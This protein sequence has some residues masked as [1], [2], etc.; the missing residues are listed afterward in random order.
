[1]QRGCSHAQL[2]ESISDI[3][4][5]TVMA[6]QPLLSHTYHTVGG[7]RVLLRYGAVLCFADFHENLRFGNGG[8]AMAFLSERNAT[9]EGAAR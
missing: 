4:V 5:K 1:M 8:N 3:V 7:G 2:V 9:A 6:I